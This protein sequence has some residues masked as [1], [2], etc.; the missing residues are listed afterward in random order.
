LNRVEDAQREVETA[1]Q[2]NPN[3]APSHY[4]LGRIYHTLGKSDLSVQQFKLTKDLLRS[5]NGNSD[6]MSSGDRK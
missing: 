5:G 1:V 4:L 6:P 2:L 3:D